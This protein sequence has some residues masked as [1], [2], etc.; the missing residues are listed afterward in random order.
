MQEAGGDK[1]PLST[2]NVTELAAANLGFDIP[3]SPEKRQQTLDVLQSVA[4]EVQAPR[5]LGTAALALAWVAAGRLDAYF[6]YTLSAWDMAAAA[7]L[8]QES[9]GAI[10]DHQ[11][12]PWSWEIREATNCVASNGHLHDMIFPHLT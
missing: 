2:S 10:F 8:L 11:K 6:N 5:N 9:G 3:R 1:R 7:L 4:H 12:R